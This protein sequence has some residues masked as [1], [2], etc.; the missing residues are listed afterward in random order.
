MFK[1]HDVSNVND[2]IGH[3]IKDHDLHYVVSQVSS[4]GKL[5]ADYGIT[6]ADRTKPRIFDHIDDNYEP[7][8]E[9]DII[10]KSIGSLLFQCTKTRP[11]IAYA[12]NCLE[13]IDI[14]CKFL[15][16]KLKNI[17]IFHCGTNN[18]L[19]DGLTK[20]VSNGGLINGGVLET[21]T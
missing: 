3:K 9:E 16:E 7:L 5:L 20:P 1:T 4:I 15:I 2:C 17:E 11:N 6:K 13:H 19:A 12:V 21:I 8:V 10:K 18:Q 14:D